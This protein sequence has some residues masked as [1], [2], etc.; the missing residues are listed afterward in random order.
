MSPQEN[1]CG[2]SLFGLE[3]KGDEMKSRRGI[4]IVQPKFTKE[5]TSKRLRAMFQVTFS[6]LN[7]NASKEELDAIV[8][9]ELAKRAER[10][11][12]AKRHVIKNRIIVALPYDEKHEF[13][14]PVVAKCVGTSRK[15]C[16]KCAVPLKIWPTKTLSGKTIKNLLCYRCGWTNRVIKPLEMPSSTNDQS[17]PAKAP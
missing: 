3:I 9:H 1:T 2:D 4:P 6:R 5:E 12:R 13:K 14:T 16:P 10:V 17:Q 11:A 8:E 7:K 15:K